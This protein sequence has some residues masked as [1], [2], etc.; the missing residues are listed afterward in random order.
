MMKR[1]VWLCQELDNN[2]WKI[3][4]E[5]A[6]SFWVDMY[7]QGFF[8]LAVK[9][10]PS[11]KKGGSILYWAN[12]FDNLPDEKNTPQERCLMEV[13]LK[14]KNEVGLD[15]LQKVEILD[16]RSR[17]SKYINEFDDSINV[18]QYIQETRPHFWTEFLRQSFDTV[19]PKASGQTHTKPHL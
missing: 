14:W 5:E 10:A 7:K 1:E 8:K 19:L 15:E 13:L 17:G 2:V 4:K 11:F 18:S 9:L 6:L 16:K 12:L 3:K